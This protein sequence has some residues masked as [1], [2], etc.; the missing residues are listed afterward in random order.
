M[1]LLRLFFC[2]CV[3][4]PLRRR[5]R[6][7]HARVVLVKRTSLALSLALLDTTEKFPEFHSLLMAHFATAAAAAAAKEF[8]DM[9]AHQPETA[10]VVGPLRTPFPVSQK[11]VVKTQA[12]FSGQC[13]TGVL[14]I[15]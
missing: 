7:R 2:S 3:N 15:L 4:F 9:P 12:A 1:E 8:Q 6:R 13:L 5:R 10:I 11:R 14:A